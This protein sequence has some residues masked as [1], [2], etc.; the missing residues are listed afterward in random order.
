MLADIF[1]GRGLARDAEAEGFLLDLHFHAYSPPYM[2]PRRD[3]HQFDSSTC[4]GGSYAFCREQRFSS[5]QT[6]ALLGIQHALMERDLA[7]SSTSSLRDSYAHFEAL[8]LAHSV[9]RS[10]KRFVRLAVSR[11]AGGRRADV[12]LAASVMLFSPEQAAAIV[13]FVT[14]TYFRHLELYKSVFTP[15]RHVVLVQKDVNSVQTPRVPRPLA[16]AVLHTPPV[17]ET[18]VDTKDEGSAPEG[19][20]LIDM[21]VDG[22]TSDS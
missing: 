14:H 4:G 21:E 17:V 5:A 22:V 7:A 19:E 10:P 16:D 12:G 11:P 6:S 1:G 15:F 18:P 3:R 20:S 2:H 13:D 9:N 8:L